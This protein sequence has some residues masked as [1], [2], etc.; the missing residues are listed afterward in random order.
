MV[1]DDNVDFAVARLARGLG[2]SECVDKCGDLK[3][4]IRLTC[5]GNNV[6]FGVARL[7]RWV[8]VPIGF[9][10]ISIELSMMLQLF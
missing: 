1:G 2:V 4:L 6:D 10:R 9:G 8:S 5:C 3:F 7:P